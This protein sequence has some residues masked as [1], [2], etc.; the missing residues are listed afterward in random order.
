MIVPICWVRECVVR[1]WCIC[2]GH[3]QERKMHLSLE[4]VGLW[5]QIV[6]LSYANHGYWVKSVVHP[7][8]RLS[9]AWVPLGERVGIEVA[10]RICAL[11]LPCLSLV[12]S[13]KCSCTCSCKSPTF[14]GSRV[15]MHM[16]VAIWIMWTVKPTQPLS[17]MQVFPRRKAPTSWVSTSA[18]P[19]TISL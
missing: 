5:K 19:A 13:L 7:S 9:Q 17:P 16:I 1:K 8:R 15:R 4:R 18:F 6:F 12:E 14:P 3:F 11:A 2:T 10:M